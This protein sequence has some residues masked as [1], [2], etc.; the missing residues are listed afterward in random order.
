M[1][2]ATAELRR[3]MLITRDA[4][5]ALRHLKS[6]VDLATEKIHAAELQTSGM[7]V[8]AAPG[9]DFPGTLRA[10]AEML[11]SPKFENS[12]KQAVAKVETAV[13]WHSVKTKAAHPH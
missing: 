8:G 10:A 3:G 6:L 9:E 2:A 12:L 4:H 1:T 7:T 11:H 13:A 5:D